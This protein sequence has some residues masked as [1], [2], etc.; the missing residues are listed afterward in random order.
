VGPAE[1]HVV[2][3]FGG[4]PM[5]SLQRW[6]GNRVYHP[7]VPGPPLNGPATRDVTQLP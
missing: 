3:A 5:R 6:V 4:L 2:G 7:S 1:V